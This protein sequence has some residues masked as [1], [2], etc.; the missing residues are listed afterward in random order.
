MD[1]SVFNDQLGRAS[2]LAPDRCVHERSAC[3]NAVNYNV[4][5]YVRV[6]LRAE[7]V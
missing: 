7:I 2:R 4:V 3:A 1:P 6:Q 5:N